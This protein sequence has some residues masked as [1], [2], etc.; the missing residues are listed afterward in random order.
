MRTH[1]QA[2]R[3]LAVS[4]ADLVQD[5]APATTLARVQA[6]WEKAAGS[7]ISA[8]SQ[9]IREHEGTLTLACSS[10]SWAQEID[11]MASELV[12]N[13]NTELGDELIRGLRFRA[14]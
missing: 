4:L 8:A 1:R 7:R 13:L 9:P 10:S 12:E 2:P 14:C 11:M 5:I 6:V 3:D